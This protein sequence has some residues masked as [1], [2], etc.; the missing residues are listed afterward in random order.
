MATRDPIWQ[1]LADEG[2]RQSWLAERI[3]YDQAHISRIKSGLLTAT[4][5]FR[6]RCAEALGRP[7]SELFYGRL[8]YVPYDTTTPTGSLVTA[9]R[10]T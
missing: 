10:G 1:I 5:T 3:G 2:R 4:P 6:A 7:E 8:V 9:E